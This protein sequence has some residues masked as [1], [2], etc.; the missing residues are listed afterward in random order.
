MKLTVEVET[1]DDTE[2]VI[3]LYKTALATAPLQ[4]IHNDKVV[5]IFGDSTYNFELADFI[6]SLSEEERKN[7]L[8]QS[9]IHALQREIELLEKQL[10]T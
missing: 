4:T 5:V 7:L 1:Y 8:V 6:S 2:D 3:S 10:I 9:K